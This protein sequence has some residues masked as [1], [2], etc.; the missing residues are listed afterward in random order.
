VGNGKKALASRQWVE[1]VGSKQW[2]TVVNKQWATLLSEYF[3][4]NGIEYF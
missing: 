3:E 1:A 2:A 4:A